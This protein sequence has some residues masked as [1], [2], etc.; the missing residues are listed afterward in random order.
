MPVELQDTL[1]I[2]GALLSFA[3]IDYVVVKIVNYRDRK[4][5]V[6]RGAIKL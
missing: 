1:I 5:P 3:G 2:A 6:L 4:Q